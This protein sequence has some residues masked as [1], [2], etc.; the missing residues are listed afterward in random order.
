[1]AAFVLSTAVLLGILYLDVWPGRKLVFGPVF[2]LSLTL[3]LLGYLLLAL[4]SLGIQ[5]PSPLGLL[6]WL[7]GLW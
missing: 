5:V 7:I 1:M 6:G 3:L 4:T 2:S